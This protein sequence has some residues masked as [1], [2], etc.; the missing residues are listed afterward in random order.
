MQQGL[1]EEK[2]RLKMGHLQRQKA[3]RRPLVMCH[4]WLRRRRRLRRLAALLLVPSS[5]RAAA[6]HGGS[7]SSV[8]SRLPNLSAPRHPPCLGG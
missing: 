3:A 7:G 8:A 1:L 2:T 5:R 6:A 4:A